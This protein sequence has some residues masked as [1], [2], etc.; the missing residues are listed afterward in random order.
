MVGK[1]LP[2]SLRSGVARDVV[3]TLLGHVSPSSMDPYLH[4]SDQEKRDAVE[5]VAARRERQA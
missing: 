4:A 3:Q 5:R 2:T 1:P